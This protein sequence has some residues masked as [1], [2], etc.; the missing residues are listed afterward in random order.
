MSGDAPS[1]GGVGLS[2]AAE[3]LYRALLAD[4]L[5]TPAALA[6]AA[7]VESADYP[8]LL[9]ELSGRGL[10]ARTDGRLV[11]V[12]PRIGLGALV[13]E[14]QSNLDLATQAITGL[15]AAF[16]EGQ[17][18]ADPSRL[19]EVVDGPERVAAAMAS[20]VAEAATEVAV[21]DAPPYVDKKT[22]KRAETS[23]LDRGVRSRAI[24]AVAALEVPGYYDA[25]QAMIAAGEMARVVPTVP[26]KLVV[27][28]GRRA[29]LPLAIHDGV[30]RSA[31]LVHPSALAEA[32]AALFE[33]VWDTGLPIPGELEEV[34]EPL[35]AE[36]RE[37]LRL[38]NAGVKDEAIARRLGVSPR[39]LSRRVTRLLERLGSATRF[40]AGLQAAR[41]GWLL[42]VGP[43]EHGPTAVTSRR[44][45]PSRRPRP[46]RRRG[47]SSP[48]S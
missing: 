48:C 10:T 19:A 4:P 3:R 29:L 6:A 33:S 12:D 1:L 5:A 35:D 24:Y 46:T 13:R 16:T 47:R 15:V 26:L 9:A 22:S 44:C 41:R 37:L 45:R 39:T 36:E 20:I 28:D 30:V 11:A 43:C 25:V 14:R 38:L 8:A 18:R 40:Q 34:A 17:L 2:G 21:F 32:L 27:V 31:I 7:A 42:G 23:L